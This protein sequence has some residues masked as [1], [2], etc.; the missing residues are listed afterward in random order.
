MKASLQADVKAQGRDVINF[1]TER[2]VVTQRFW[3]E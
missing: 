1:F 3:S 2:K